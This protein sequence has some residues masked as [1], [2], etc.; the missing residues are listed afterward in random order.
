MRAVGVCVG[1]TRK[2]EA[3][4]GLGRGRPMPNSW[5]E[6]EGEEEE[7]K[8]ETLIKSE[9]NKLSSVFFFFQFIIMVTL[10]ENIQ[11]TNGFYVRLLFI[12]GFAINLICISRCTKIIGTYLLSYSTFL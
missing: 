1:D 12:Y 6:A 11:I 7:D 5:E 3:S 2:F 9:K 8:L 10:N 4:G